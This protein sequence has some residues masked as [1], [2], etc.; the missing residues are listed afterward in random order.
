MDVENAKEVDY[1]LEEVQE[2]TLEVVEDTGEEELEEYSDGVQKR[3][4]KLTYKYR[5]EKKKLH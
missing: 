5:E 4:K 2:T 1:E 3:I